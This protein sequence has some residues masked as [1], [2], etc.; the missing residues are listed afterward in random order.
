MVPH[1]TEVAGIDAASKLLYVVG[2]R[3]RKHLHLISERGR[4]LGRQRHYAATDVL[5]ACVFDYDD[6]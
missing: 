3:A 4:P 1:F 5:A 2:S 6:C